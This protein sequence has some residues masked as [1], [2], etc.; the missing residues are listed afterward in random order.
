M[1]SNGEREDSV[2][3]NLKSKSR[4]STFHPEN[5]H[6]GALENTYYMPP[7]EVNHLSTQIKDS[8]FSPESSLV[9]GSSCS[10]LNLLRTTSVSNRPHQVDAVHPFFNGYRSVKFDKSTSTDNQVFY[11]RQ[12]EISIELCQEAVNQHFAAGQHTPIE[13][14]CVYCNTN[15]YE[16][17]YNENVCYF[18]RC[19][20][21]RQQNQSSVSDNSSGT[22]TPMVSSIKIQNAKESV[23]SVSDK[24][25]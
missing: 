25:T 23:K 15:V 9:D 10:T 2:D 16:Y 13:Q 14:N 19:P 8:T 20:I 4:P 3:T 21:E 1:T 5:L 11:C 24:P 12:C 22:P 6:E 18:H 7:S 17:F